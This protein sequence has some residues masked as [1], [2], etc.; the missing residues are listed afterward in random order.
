MRVLLFSLAMAFLALASP[1]LAQPRLPCE[2][3]AAPEPSAPGD[4][5][6]YEV[7]QMSW[8][9]PACSPWEE[10]RFS[11]LVALSGHL[12][13]NLD[14]LDLLARIG[15][16]SDLNKLLYWSRSRQRWRPLFA[17]SFTLSAADEEARRADFSVQEFQEGKDYY[18]WQKENANLGGVVIRMRFEK[19]ADDEI[20]LSQVNVTAPRLFG[21]AM[22]GEGEVE[23]LLHLQRNPEGYWRYYHIARIGDGEK[24]FGAGERSSYL[25]RAQAL[26][27]YLD[28]RGQEEGQPLA[29]E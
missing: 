21:L 12:S 24:T 4:L 2:G 13:A 28:G 17:E 22:M 8:H 16:P 25:N 27:R 7:W 15:A 23:T 1:A 26:I 6:A 10:R 18:L 29:R 5:P 11:A 9:A 19:I 3:E 20:I 14:A